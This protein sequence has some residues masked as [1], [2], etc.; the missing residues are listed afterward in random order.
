MEFIYINLDKIFPIN[1]TMLAFMI[2]AL[3][4]I[5]MVNTG[6]IQEFKE[7]S[8]FEDVLKDFN[9]ALQCHLISG[10]FSLVIW[11]LQIKSILILEILTGLSIVIFFIS[12]YFTYLSYKILLYFIK[13]Q[14]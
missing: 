13:K 12:F 10:L 4:I 3:T 14:I 2:T 7:T 9:R 5:Q 11:F 6:K 1:F 8:L